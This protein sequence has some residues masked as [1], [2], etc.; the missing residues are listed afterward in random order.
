MSF[1]LLGCLYQGSRCILCFFFAGSSS[2]SLAR[3]TRLA[4]GARDRPSA[5]VLYSTSSSSSSSSRFF[6]NKL[7]LNKLE[8]TH[9]GVIRRPQTLVIC[10][11]A[12]PGK[13]EQGK[14]GEEEKRRG[15][16][17]GFLLLHLLFL[18]WLGILS[19]VRGKERKGEQARSLTARQ[20]K[21]ICC[22]L[23]KKIPY[24]HIYL[25]W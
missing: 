4:A 13:R 3:L 11:P 16:Q 7:P 9:P 1:D 24:I 21:A 23:K 25:M 20:P 17:P 2:S 15:G 6:F 8:N 19:E 12:L 22:L 5:C 18:P 10:L 14:E